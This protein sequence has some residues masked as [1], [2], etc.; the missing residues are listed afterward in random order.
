MSKR[1]VVIYLSGSVQKHSIEANSVFWSDQDMQA[2]RARLEDYGVI[3]LNPNDQF[4]TKDRMAK[5]GRDVYQVLLSDVI[6]VDG[7]EKRGI[8]VGVEMAVAKY[9][10]I[11]LFT[12]LPENSYYRKDNVTIKG[13]YFEKWIHPF[14]MELSDEICSSLSEIA[15]AINIYLSETK[16]VKNASVFR[17]AIKY[18]KERYMKDDPLMQKLLARIGKDI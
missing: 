4:V 15:H 9:S 10:N 8:G 2:I 13:L 11:P 12:Y 14:I 1:Q 5:F 7:R 3:F 16:P 17:G 18:Y 6:L